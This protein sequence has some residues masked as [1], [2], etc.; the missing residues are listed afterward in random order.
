MIVIGKDKY[1]VK[2]PNALRSWALQQSIFPAAGNVVAAVAQGLGAVADGKLDVKRLLELDLTKFLPAMLP[3][4][5]AVFARMPPG[6]LERLLR[7]LLGDPKQGGESATRNGVALFSGSDGD[8]IDLLL[9]G[10][11]V[12]MWKLFLH[13]LEVWYPDFFGLVQPFIAAGKEAQA[14]AESSTS[15]QPGPASA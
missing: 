13:A 5:G 6:E 9:R 4:L 7:V 10:Q 8:A 14:S 1:E 12:V 3:Q 11:H 15:P 2:P